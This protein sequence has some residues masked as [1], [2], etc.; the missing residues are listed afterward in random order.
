MTSAN[1]GDYIDL[2]GVCLKTKMRTYP[3]SSCRVTS[4]KCETFRNLHL[5]DLPRAQQ[6]VRDEREG[7]AHVERRTKQQHGPPPPPHAFVDLVSVRCNILYTNQCM[8]ATSVYQL[9][10]R[11]VVVSNNVVNK[12]HELHYLLVDPTPSPLANGKR[13]YMKVN[14]STMPCSYKAPQKSVTYRNS[15]CAV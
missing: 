15:P 8:R 3:A 7:G 14:W 12:I 10:V 5:T 13:P 4:R 11:V 2:T 1:S 6:R 9:L